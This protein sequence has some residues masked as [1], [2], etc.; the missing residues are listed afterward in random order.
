LKL[1]NSSINP[2]RDIDYSVVS[3]GQ[4]IQVFGKRH[5]NKFKVKVSE[6]LTTQE[7]DS[8]NRLHQGVYAHPPANGDY[9]GI[10]FQG[11]LA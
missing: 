3:H 5:T 2:C 1:S 4:L 6:H 7:C 10:F 11:W 9:L 8:L